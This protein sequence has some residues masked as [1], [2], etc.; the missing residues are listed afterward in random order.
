MAV[1]LKYVLYTS[2]VRMEDVAI[3]SALK[4]EVQAMN[5][6]IRSATAPPFPAMATAAAGAERPADT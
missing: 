5:K 6:V 2:K 4:Q 1:F 3:N